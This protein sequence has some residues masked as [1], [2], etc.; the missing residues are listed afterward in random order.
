ME[1]NVIKPISTDIYFKYTPLTLPIAIYDNHNTFLLNKDTEYIFDD[2]FDLKFNPYKT[3][4][5]INEIYKGKTT[6][7]N[8]N[9]NL[10]YR[11]IE[12]ERVAPRYRLNV[13]INNKLIK[14]ILHGLYDKYDSVN[15]LDNNIIIDLEYNDKVSITLKK[16][17]NNHHKFILYKNSF[18]KFII[19]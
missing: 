18:Y 4:N 17:Q 1:L 10:N 9:L 12:G 14:S 16:L 5:F 19:F 7:F 3:S 11:W 6:K 8:L 13:Y 2:I 15:I